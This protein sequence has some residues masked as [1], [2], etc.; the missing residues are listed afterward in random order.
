MSNQKLIPELRFPEF[1]EDG[2]W[3]EGEWKREWR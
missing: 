2:E 1:V 3:V